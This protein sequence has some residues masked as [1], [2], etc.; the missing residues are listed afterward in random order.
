MD[1]EHSLRIN[2]RRALLLY[3]CATEKVEDALLGIGLKQ[4]ANGLFRDLLADILLT[5]H[6]RLCR[7]FARYQRRKRDPTATAVK[8]NLSLLRRMAALPILEM[9]RVARNYLD[10]ERRSYLDYRFMKAGCKQAL[11]DLV[12]SLTALFQCLVDRRKTTWSEYVEICLP[13]ILDAAHIHPR[14]YSSRKSAWTRYTFERRLER[15]GGARIVRLVAICLMS[16]EARLRRF[17]PKFTL[18]ELRQAPPRYRCKFAGKELEHFLE[19]RGR[20]Q[21]RSLLS[22]S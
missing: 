7:R 3:L 16:S 21:Y 11:D 5:C 17:R 9:R 13:L 19:K 14:P 8:A 2:E 18:E 22:V 20:G 12:L 6:Q 1:R 10:I 15:A 4:D